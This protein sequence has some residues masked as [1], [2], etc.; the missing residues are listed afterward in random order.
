M[1]SSHVE[2]EVSI[3]VYFRTMFNFHYLSV[4][5]HPRPSPEHKLSYDSLHSS[6]FCKYILTYFVNMCIHL[7]NFC[8]EF[9]SFEENHTLFHHTRKETP[10]C[11]MYV[12]FDNILSLYRCSQNIS[13]HSKIMSLSSLKNIYIEYSAFKLRDLKYSY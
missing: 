8:T 4:C 5:F 1:C 6:I 7:C 12:G 11:I 10:W 2:M 3:R 9:A 13:E